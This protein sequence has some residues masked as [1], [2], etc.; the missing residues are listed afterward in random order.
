MKAPVRTACLGL[1]LAFGLCGP[2]AMAQP[3]A[4]LRTESGL[5]TGTPGADPA[6]HVYRG[7]PYAAPPVGPLRWQP[8]EP[9]VAWTGVRAA[10]RFAPGCPQ[11][12]PRS[13][14]PWTE[15]FMHQGPV[16][17]DCL[18]LNV[19][20][21][22]ADSSE[23]R[24]VLVY[25]HGGGFTEGSGSV[26][27]YDGEALARK[28]LVVVTFNYRLGVL[29]FLAH[30][31]LTAASKHRASGNYGLLDQVAALR[32]VQRNIA[33]FG[34]DP[35]NVTI[36]G[37][38]AGAMSV[39]L[40]TASPLAGGLFHRAIVQ[41]GPG[42]LA[43]FGIATTRELARPLAEA[44]RQGELFAGAR[45]AETLQALRE[46]PVETLLAPTEGD[47]PGR[48]GPVVDGW[49]LPENPADLYARGQQ[50][51]VPLL[52]GMNA[53]EPS[54]FPGYGRMTAGA[55]REQARTRYGDRAE[56]FLALYPA[57]TDEEAG[58]AQKHSTRDMALAAMRRVADERAATSR[59]PA[60]LYLFERAIPWPEHPEYGAFHSAELPYVF[61]NL[62]LLGRPWEPLDRHLAGLMSSYWAR[63]AATG[64]PAAPVRG[65][66]DLPAWPAYD[67]SA[68]V[69]MV[70]GEATGPRVLPG[71]AA[72]RFFGL[73]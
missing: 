60:Y 59:T 66:E 1:L 61:D 29:G 71:E 55:F 58:L 47:P 28:G 38:S 64:D 70:F 65:A 57:A 10:D 39:Y 52:M 2:V 45:G 37:Q 14:L 25:I 18:Y 16:D 9:P 48:F 42:A 41:S 69:L 53:D 40:L 4:P 26:P 36:A 22:A 34:G 20:T 27:L 7:I 13:R 31:A 15:P 8:P 68:G 3:A 73:Q 67:P 11:P 12:L 30:P 17:E 54:A 32:W 33:A 43:A 5:V 23:R 35:G 46:M 51:D 63:F 21:A 24:P 49:F 19:W 72:R 62:R 50:H 56:D 44:E 6:V